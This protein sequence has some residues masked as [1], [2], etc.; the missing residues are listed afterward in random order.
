M[1]AKRPVIGV[2]GGIASGKSLVSET[3]ASLGGVRIDA[4]R[5]GH[6]VLQLPEVRDLLVARWGAGILDS[7][8]Q[9]DR[10]RVAE[11]AFQ[12]P[13]R[14]ELAFLEQVTHPRIASLAEAILATVPA[15]TWAILD[16]ALLLE[17][18]WDRLCGWIIFVDA[19]WEDRLRRAAT[20][21]WDAAELERREARQ[22]P[23][24]EKRRR[25]DVVFT[26]HG[27]REELA[28]QVTHWWHSIRDVPE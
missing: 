5:L 20:R 8:G 10:R 24:A 4:D 16:A 27:S 6:Q 7:G 23:L 21:G 12:S 25:A 26:N 11:K 17:A 13:G 15:G 22:W 3:L 28:A 14:G 1:T 9:V 19:P 2:V 18:G